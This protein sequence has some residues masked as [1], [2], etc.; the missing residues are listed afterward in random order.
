MDCHACSTRNGGCVA[1]SAKAL[2]CGRLKPEPGRFFRPFPHS[3]QPQGRYPSISSCLRYPFPFF[4]LLQIPYKSRFVAALDVSFKHPLE[5]LVEKVEQ[6]SLNSSR[7][8]SHL[9]P[10]RA[11]IEILRWIFSRVGHLS[12]Y[13]IFRSFF[14]FIFGHLERTII[15]EKHF[16]FGLFSKIW[17]ILV[18]PR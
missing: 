15:V 4:F 8:P 3:P 17:R 14:I 18:N 1:N 9:R 5:S 12:M 2:V 7:K 13:L 10:R 11:I 6:G 16:P